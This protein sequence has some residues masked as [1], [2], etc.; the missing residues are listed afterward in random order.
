MPTLVTISREL[1]ISGLLTGNS[2]AHHEMSPQRRVQRTTLRDGIDILVWEGNFPQPLTMHV[3]DDWGRVQFCCALRGRSHYSLVHGNRRRDVVLRA[4]MNCI[5][6]TPD[7]RYRSTH[8]GLMETVTIAVRPDI[9]HDLLPEMD[10]GLS[11]QIGSAQY[12]EVSRSNAQMNAIAYS[13]M[14]ALRNTTPST[15]WLLGQSLVLVSLTL[16]AHERADTQPDTQTAQF[17][18]S[19]RQKL[20]QA[21]DY[22]LAD[23]SAAPTIAMLARKTGLGVFKLKRGFRQLF[24][25]SV[26]GLFQQERMH[27]ARRRLLAGDSSVMVVASDMGYANASH[28]ATAFQKQF[29]I[30]PSAL[31]L[32]R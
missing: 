26:Y 12:C 6:Y 32:R 9:L 16:A 4:G 5:S 10:A 25:H 13:L 3:R 18:P 15:L 20:L 11:A 28:F 29:G 30:K 1:S 2:I 17:S 7:S 24:Q 14:M 23:L 19:E 27:E 8:A 31:K 21:R 22:L